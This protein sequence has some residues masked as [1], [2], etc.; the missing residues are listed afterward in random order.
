MHRLPLASL[1]AAALFLGTPGLSQ[2]QQA[3]PSDAPR[4]SPTPPPTPG[5]PVIPSLPPLPSAEAPKQAAPPPGVPSI[6]SLPA[7]PGSSSEALAASTPPPLAAASGPANQIIPGLMNPSISFNGLFV[8]GV[9]LDDG[10]VARP[11]LG[12]EATEHAFPTAGQSFGTGMN[13]QEM[14]LQILSAVDPYFK[15]NAILS[16]PGTEGIEVEE[17]YVTLVSIPRLLINIGKLKEPFGRENTQHTHA[18]LMIDPSLINQRVFG[19]EGLNDMTVN[20][21]WLLPTSWYSELT[22]GVD[23]GSN[24]VVLG[25]GQAGGLGFLAHW[26]NL[27]DLSDDYTA[28][29]GVSGLT[30]ENAFRNQ[31][32]VGGLDLTIKGHGSGFHQWNR[33]IWQSEYLYM[34]RAGAPKDAR[35]GGLYSTLEYSL[36]Q[37]FW[38]GGRVDVVGLP[39]PEEGGRT[40]GASAILVLAP[41]EFSAV[42]L[43]Y[44]HQFVP[45]GHGIDQVL[46]QLN[47]TI[48]VHP[49]HS[50]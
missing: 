15:A 7:L 49:A 24:E 4:A 17:G 36:N 43:Q 5:V 16:I 46:M 50:Y 25:S 34:H 32:F 40:Y 41:T 11:H 30:G 6:P 8:G 48:G 20:A 45:G 42:R 18:L 10:K 27:I 9:E 28:A 2:A 3:P 19:D 22:F 33:L 37:R 21:A 1:A 14:E 35:L 31:S 44:Q 26:S 23:R 38:V 12:G 29:I 39:E 13:V 47:F